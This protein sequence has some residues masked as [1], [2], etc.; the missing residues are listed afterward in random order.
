MRR[1][2]AHS[3]TRSRSNVQTLRNVHL[4]KRVDQH[5]ETDTTGHSPDPLGTTFES[6]PPP[7]RRSTHQHFESDYT[8]RLRTGEGTCD[9]CITL[10]HMQQ[11]RDA[12]RS[13]TAQDNA[14]LALIED[15][16]AAGDE[17]VDAIYAMV[18]GVEMDGLDPSTV[19][20]A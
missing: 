12:D 8:R 15:E 16:L 20:E 13:S 6:P 3:H 17:D 7:P 4:R 18:A 14:T 1:T 10:D 5:D 11:L 9:G 2:Q 19:N